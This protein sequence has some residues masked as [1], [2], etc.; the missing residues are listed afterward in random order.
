MIEIKDVLNLLG[1]EM[2][3][4]SAQSER[5]R[6][7]IEKGKWTIEQIEKWLDECIESNSGAHDPYNRVFQDLVISLGTRLGFEVEYGRYV[8]KSKGD[9][10]DGIWR[11]KNGDAIVLEVKIST[12]P[13]GSIDQLGKY[14]ESLLKKGDN[15]NI[16]GLY[17]IGKGDT[18]PLIEQIQGSKYKDLMRLIVYKDLIEIL[19]LKED[20]E[21]VIGEG[22]SIEKIQNLLLPVES[23]NIGNIVRLLIEIATTKSTA[24]EEEVEEEEDSDKEGEKDEL[25]T[26]TELLPYLKDSKPYQRILLSALVQIE[27]E[28]A[29]IKKVIFMMNEIVKRRPT[30]GIDKK[31]TGLSIAGARAGLKMR[32][33]PLG[34][35]DIIDSSK[36]PAGP[37]K[38]YKIQDEYKQTVIDWV[39]GENL[40]I[41]NEIQ[42]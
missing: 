18:K 41:K 30:E 28:P 36:N 24:V 34:K 6:E 16:F 19:T 27:R 39:K 11:R 21:P 2:K 17:V 5:F 35:E 26:K 42:I 9:N 32:R 37:G 10:Y 8:G 12:W 25:W 38:V 29:P 40:W 13:I 20:L 31:V 33:K 15:E 3:D 23:I 1:E 4:S 22:Q 7:F 14:L